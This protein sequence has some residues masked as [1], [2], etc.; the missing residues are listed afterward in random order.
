MNLIVSDYCGTSTLCYHYEQADASNAMHAW[1]N[2]TCNQDSCLLVN[3]NGSEQSN[4]TFIGNS[5][6]PIAGSGSGNRKKHHN[7]DDNKRSITIIAVVTVCT[8]VSICLLAVSVRI[9]FYKTKYWTVINRY[10]C[11]SLCSTSSRNE[12]VDAP[13]SFHS[14]MVMRSN[15]SSDLPSYTNQD[16]SPPKY[17]QAIVTQI[18]DMR[19][20]DHPSSS[21][22][23][24]WAPVCV[25]PGPYVQQDWATHT[26]RHQTLPN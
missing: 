16:A 5:T 26:M 24:A 4:G 14:E 18:R 2:L 25:R 8:I 12:T 22:Q 11:C 6:H 1:G 9:L 13:P 20:A 15:N 21:T 23:A 17:E 3:T 10:F 7:N 19:H